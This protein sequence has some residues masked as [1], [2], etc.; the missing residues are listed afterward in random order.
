MPS[1]GGKALCGRN[2]RLICARAV[3][4]QF[5]ILEAVALFSQ[6]ECNDIFARVLNLHCEL[7]GSRI[8]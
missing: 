6:P 2:L 7:R 4:L 5:K 1:V 8:G 3:D